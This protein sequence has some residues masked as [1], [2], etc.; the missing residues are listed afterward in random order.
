MP[1]FS[2]ASTRGPQQLADAAKAAPHA[3]DPAIVAQKKAAFETAQ[4]AEAIALGDW[5]KSKNELIAAQTALDGLQSRV[6]DLARDNRQLKEAT[7]EGEALKVKIGHLDAFVPIVPRDPERD[8]LIEAGQVKDYRPYV[9][10][11]IGGVT[12][13]AGLVLIVRS[14][15]AIAGP[16]GGSRRGSLDEEPAPFATGRASAV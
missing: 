11:A 9:V 1:I 13:L 8:N 7:D 16:N 3:P 4:Q 12:L 14:R 10:G 2:R 15:R 5:S 6:P